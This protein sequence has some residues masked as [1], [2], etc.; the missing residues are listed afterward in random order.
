MLT[1]SEIQREY[2]LN[3]PKA[4]Q[5]KDILD[6]AV[7]AEREAW[8]IKMLSIRDMIIDD[9]ENEIMDEI[10][11]F[12]YSLAGPD[13]KEVNPWEEWEAIRARNA[14]SK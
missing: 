9:E 2:K 4:K 1:I 6:K 7:K 12:I 10:Y 5:L 13:F 8:I 11:H 14:R 3:Y